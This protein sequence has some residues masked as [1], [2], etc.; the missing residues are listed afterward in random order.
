MYGLDPEDIHQMHSVF[1]KYAAI[2]KAILYGSRAVGNYRHNS[3]IDLTLRGNGLT[4]IELL[5]IENALDNLLLPYKIDL[6][7]YE[8][9]DNEALRIHI[10]RV[11]KD[12]YISSNN[13]PM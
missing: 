1:E 3:D 7:I 12:F 11:G 2:E 13:K 6:S 9:I 5:E 8:K 10:D 4:F